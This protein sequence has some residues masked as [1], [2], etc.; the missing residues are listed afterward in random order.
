MLERSFPVSSPDDEILEVT[1]ADIRRKQM[2]SLDTSRS[3]GAEPD[4]AAKRNI[5]CPICMD[6]ESTVSILGSFLIKHLARVKQTTM[7]CA[8]CFAKFLQDDLKAMLHVLP[9]TFKPLSQQ[10]N[11]LQVHGVNTD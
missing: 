5:T 6:D 3:E 11:V 4:T 2:S 8:A 1:D 7:K 10:I 9:L